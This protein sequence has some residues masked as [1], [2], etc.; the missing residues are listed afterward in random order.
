MPFPRIYNIVPS[1]SPSMVK[2]QIL[3]CPFSFADASPKK[4]FTLPANA[5]IVTTQIKIDVAFDDPLA[6]LSIGDLG[7]ADKYMKTTENDP[8]NLAEYE[9][10]PSEFNAV[11]KDVYLSLS[12]G[13]SIQGSGYVVLEYGLQP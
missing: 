7:T 9:T 12:A 8:T 5:L 11:A 1:I 4:V 3:D 10:N 2:T 6:T 13:T